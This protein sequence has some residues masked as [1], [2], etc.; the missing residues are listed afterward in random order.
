M[1]NID[2]PDCQEGFAKFRKFLKDRYKVETL[3]DFT[4]DVFGTIWKEYRRENPESRISDI[5]L[6]TSLRQS[7]EAQEKWGDN[8]TKNE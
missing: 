6:W 5:A 2:N 8:P 7:L 1:L 4:A 3:E